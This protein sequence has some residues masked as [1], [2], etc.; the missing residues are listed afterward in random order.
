MQTQN[1]EETDRIMR[2]KRAIMKKRIHGIVR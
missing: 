1:S 2:I